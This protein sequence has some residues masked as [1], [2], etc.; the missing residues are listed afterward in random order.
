MGFPF[1]TASWTDVSGPIFMGTGT[2]MP[3]I[4]TFIAIVVCVVAL[5]LGQRAEAK[6]YKNHK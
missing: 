2:S 1:D 5:V 4:V 3:G 6:K